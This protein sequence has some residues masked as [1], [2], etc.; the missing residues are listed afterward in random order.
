[1]PKIYIENKEYEIQEGKNLLE[2]SLSLGLNLPYFCWH[3]KMGSVGACRQCAVKQFKDKDD[4]H[5]KIVMACME[6]VKDGMRL[7][8]E[9]NEATEFRS[10]IIESLMTNHPHDCPTCDE[11]GEC[12]LQDMTLMSG[13]SYRQY[14]FN[15]RTF[16]NQYLGP[17]INH[18]MNRC[19]ACYRCVRFY[20]DYAGG[21]DLDVLS[22]HNNVYFGRQKDGVLESEFSGNLAEICPTGVF[23]DKTLKKHYTRKW[24]FTSAPSICNLCSLG[25]NIIA[26][27]RYGEIRRIRSRYNENVNGYFICDRGRFG[28]EYMNSESRISVP[29]VLDN[30][31]STYKKAG[32]QEILGSMNEVFK[33]SNTIVGIGSARAS[34]ESNFALK[35]LVGEHNFFSCQSDQDYDLSALATEILQKTPARIYSLKNIEQSDCVVILGEDLTNTAPMMALAVRQA[36]RQKPMQKVE[37]LS[38]RKWND[39]AVREIVQEERG[40]VYSLTTCPTKLDE[41]SKTSL[42]LTPAKIASL[43]FAVAHYIDEKSS[44]PSGLSSELRELAREIARELA[45]SVNAVIIAGTSC[46][47]EDILKAAANIASARAAKGKVTGLS[48]VFPDSNALGLS[49]LGSRKLSELETEKGKGENCLVVLESD[50][51]RNLPEKNA[52]ILLNAFDHV[53]SID[54]LENKTNQKA[55]FVLPAAAITESDGHLVSN[56]GRVQR[57]FSVHASSESIQPSWKWIQALAG[58]SGKEQLASMEHLEDYS[59]AIELECPVFKGLKDIASSSAFRIGAQKIARESHR[60]SGRTSIHANETLNEPQPPE[61]EN[62]PMS[63]S[64]EGFHGHTPAPFN[65]YFWSP[66]WN[67]VQSLNKYQIEIGGEIHREM[68]E[69]CIFAERKGKETEKEYFKP[70]EITGLSKD[71]WTFVPLYHI[72][73]SENI[74]VRDGAL[75]ELVPAPYIAL[76]PEDAEKRGWK[77]GTKVELEISAL[78]LTLGVKIMG[79]IPDHA[80]GLPVGLEG[81]P[82]FGFAETLKLKEI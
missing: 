13:H 31:T 4:T 8:I 67:S 25:C 54:S 65:P 33:W 16:T 17:L 73:G 39:K 77:D 70:S 55:G 29:L 66:G 74:S 28:Y 7:S 49:L 35:K 19:I 61:D 23:T 59:S 62:S 37:K 9:D 24:D 42:P 60:Y 22:A 45:E 76:N 44:L 26:G 82:V 75:K 48:L 11:G 30:T 81:I 34:L 56:E 2:T 18:E 40:P 64:M 36:S 41:L 10:H 68:P 80:A 6:E 63:Y 57:F 51:Y 47:N 27:E 15:K 72:F 71:E 21:K 53:V 38:I 32:L 69:L 14:R 79:G 20:K 3:P 78:T 5:G 50:L 46:L 12:H 52:D 43:G 1:M 58:I